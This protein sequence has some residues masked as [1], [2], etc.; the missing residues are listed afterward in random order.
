MDKKWQIKITDE[1][2]ETVREYVRKTY[3]EK[4][5]QHHLL[6]NTAA[7]LYC[8]VR[9]GSGHPEYIGSGN[10]GT[11]TDITKEELARIIKGEDPSKKIIGYR[12][13]KD[14][15]KG[16]VKTG[17]VYTNEEN[18]V[19]YMPREDQDYKSENV[20]FYSLAPEIVEE[21]EPV[22]EEEDFEA[23]EIVFVVKD[24]DDGG[25]RYTGV[26]AEYV[27][28]NTGEYRSDFKHI[29]QA[30][31]GQ[32]VVFQVRKATDEE[33]AQFEENRAIT[34]PGYTAEFN[35]DK[36]EVSFGCQTFKFDEVETIHKLLNR[37][38][39]GFELTTNGKV[40]PKDAVEE[41]YDRMKKAQ[42]Q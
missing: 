32:T 42:K 8:E 22:Y 35:D 33:K 16:E 7:Y 36:T 11:Y 31:D 40:I 37:R 21:W 9:P 14:L 28:P 23:G 29:I 18:G 13:P 25:G 38:D 20:S 4:D 2:R 19:L 6:E 24:Y 5:A 39:G 34:V 26:I 10:S 15:F 3:G 17:E 27:K 1:N 41:V 12:V 30:T